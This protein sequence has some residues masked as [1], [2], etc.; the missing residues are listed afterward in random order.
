M[1]I[2]CPTT[3]TTIT[4]AAAAAGQQGNAAPK[5]Q[6]RHGEIYL[7][8]L[9]VLVHSFGDGSGGCLLGCRRFF[10]ASLSLSHCARSQVKCRCLFAFVH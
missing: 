8:L 1:H 2:V 9:C 5:Q 6:I 3:T 10:A 7:L 4:A